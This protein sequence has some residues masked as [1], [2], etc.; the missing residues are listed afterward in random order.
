MTTLSQ[1]DFDAVRDMHATAATLNKKRY[2]Y[3]M[4]ERTCVKENERERE[5]EQTTEQ[6]RTQRDAATQGK[7]VRE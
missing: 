3:N 5:R 4:H 6:K 1:R 7:R 2:K